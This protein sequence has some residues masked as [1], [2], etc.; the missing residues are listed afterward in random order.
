MRMS[1]SVARRTLN[2]LRRTIPRGQAE[3]DELFQLIEFFEQALKDG[4]NSTAR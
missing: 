3:A 4:R 2:F 1:P